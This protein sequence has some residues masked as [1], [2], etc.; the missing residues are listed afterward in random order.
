MSN[1]ALLWVIALALAGVIAAPG[2]MAIYIVRKRDK[3]TPPEAYELM[4]NAIGELTQ[5]SLQT[6]KEMLRMQHRIGEL[7]LG[8]QVLSSQIRRLNHTPE[9]K[10]AATEARPEDSRYDTTALHR[11][12]ARQFNMDELNDLAFQMR[13]QTG[14][15]GEN[16]TSGRARAIINYADRRGELAQLVALC[17][18]LRPKGGF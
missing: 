7:M 10:D 17:R 8:V 3:E 9:W 4:Q 18:Q 2:W 12:M 15:L 16:T 1:D 6:N 5:Q 11:R 14:E 13:I